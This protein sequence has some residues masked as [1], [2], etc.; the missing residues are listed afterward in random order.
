[1]RRERGTGL[2]MD[3]IGVTEF[4][5]STCCGLIGDS[6]GYLQFELLIRRFLP[7]EAT[8]ERLP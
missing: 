8:P 7:E 5:S 6:I 4:R 3:D 1:M 2:L